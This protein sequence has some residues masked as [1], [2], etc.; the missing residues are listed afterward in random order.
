MDSNI[1]DASQQSENEDDNL[2]VVA[3]SFRQLREQRNYMS[4][5]VFKKFTNKDGK[6][7]ETLTKDVQGLLSI[8]EAAH[9]RVH[10]EEIL[11]Q[12]LSFTLTNLESMGP[13]FSNSSLKAQVSEALSQPIY[14]NLP[15]LGAKKYLCMYEN[16]ESHNDLLLKFAKLD[17]NIVQKLHQRE[18]G[19]LTRWWKDLVEQFP[20]AR[21]RLVDCHFYTVEIYFEPQYSR[22]R[23]MMSKVLTIYTVIDDTYDAY[24]TYDELVPFTDAIDRCGCDISAIGSVPPSLKPTY[25]ALADLYTQI[26]EKFIKEAS[27]VF[28]EESIAKETFEWMINEPLILRASSTINRL[29]GD[30]IGHN[31][32]QQRKHIASFIECYMKEFG[33]SKQDAYAEAQKKITNAWKNMN[34]DFLCS[35]HDKVLTFVLELVINIARLAY[36]FKENDF[37]SAQSEFKDKI[38]LLFVE[39]VNV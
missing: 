37:A 12:A 18:L 4:S 10:G 14:T 31:L 27:L 34:T 2:Y 33:G 26:E 25:Q 20:Y 23:E 24:A 28:M 36:I 19:D 35:T 30:C 3:L 7:K 13:K 32:E 11:E 39:P 8:Y 1:F 9:L 5:D 15:R 16:K 21:H 22:A 6:F 38:T 17:F 29:K